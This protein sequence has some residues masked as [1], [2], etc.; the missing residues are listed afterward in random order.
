MVINVVQSKLFQYIGTRL[1]NDAY[2]T[3]KCS[4]SCY[5]DTSTNNHLT[6]LGILCNIGAILF[7]VFLLKVLKVKI[8]SVLLILAI[9]DILT[10]TMNLLPKYILKV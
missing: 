9:L 10:I 7:S 8:A 3:S 2:T 6:T 5:I 1:K 4:S